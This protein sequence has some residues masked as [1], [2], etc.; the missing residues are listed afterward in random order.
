MKY[1]KIFELTNYSKKNIEDIDEEYFGDIYLYTD[2]PILIPNEESIYGYRIYLNNRAD[3][4]DTQ[5]EYIYRIKLKKPLYKKEIESLSFNSMSFFPDLLGFSKN[6]KDYSK[7]SGYFYVDIFNELQVR[8]TNYDD[9][10]DFK[11]IGGFKKYDK[12]S[13]NRKNI[14]LSEETHDFLY[15]YISGQIIHKKLTDDIKKELEQFKPLHNIKIYKGIEEVQIKHYTNIKPPYKKGQMIKANI[16]HLSSWTTNVL[17]ARRF[18]DDYSSSIPFVAMM[19][20]EPKD[21]LVD[22]RQLPEDYY[23]TNQREII[24]LPNQYD[25][26]LVWEGE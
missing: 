12:D 13:L 16:E 26:K 6:T 4:S 24:M 2:K 8:I 15:S 18:I 3:A 17:I 21:I 9:I 1:I 20:A 25:F 19:I 10:V 22:V 7:Y 14:K 23:H 11:L 5:S